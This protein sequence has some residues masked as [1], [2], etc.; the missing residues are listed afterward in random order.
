M[1]KIVA[2]FRDSFKYDAVQKTAISVRDGVIEYYGA[3]IG[4]TPTDKIFKVYRSPA[5]IAN[6]AVDMQGIPLTVDHVSVDMPVTDACGSVLT[7]RMIDLKSDDM[8]SNVGVL[9]TLDVL[10]DQLGTLATGKREL[11][12]GYR[13]TLVEMPPDSGYDF[14]QRDI[15]PHHLAIVDAGRC[16]S[17]C[18][19]ID[20]KA[21]EGTTDMK[22]KKLHK[23]FSDAEGQ[24]SLS[25]IVDIVNALPDAIASLP[26]DEAQKVMP[27]LQ[28]IVAANG[29]AAKTEADPAATDEDPKADEDT[30]AADEGAD[31][32]G[33]PKVETTDEDPEDEEKKKPFGDAKSFA[34]A[35]NKGV[36]E[37][38]QIVDRARQFLPDTYSFKGKT[39]RQIML[40]AVATEHPKTKFSDS[41][42]NVAFKLLKKTE[43]KYKSFGDS[44]ATEGKF[45]DHVKKQ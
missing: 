8:A 18:S 28:G 5:T 16:G 29:G 26:L 45:S 22:K 25:G 4:M 20:H 19:F 11:S 21:S 2:H 9:N 17:V 27:I 6:A 36:Q 33:E 31:P 35:V 3:E 12:L 42:L 1:K 30:P 37:H 10:N 44:M 39:G 15:A 7:S 43:S 34:D 32:E 41:E 14:E 24:P 23:A 13:A 40:D 38:M